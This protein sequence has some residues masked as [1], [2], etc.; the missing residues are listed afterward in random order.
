[1]FI[2]SPRR[3]TFLP[4]A[5]SSRLMKSLV[6]SS[7][8][9]R[10]EAFLRVVLPALCFPPPVMNTSNRPHLAAVLLAAAFACGVPPPGGGS[11][12][13]P[14]AGWNLVYDSGTEL[15]AIWGSGPNDVWAVGGRFISGFVRHWNGSS[16]EI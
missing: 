2:A 13:Q 1:M 7:S 15:T 9:V 16:W 10:G 4:T 5:R 6:K 14:D 3:C 8:Y 12:A 11:A